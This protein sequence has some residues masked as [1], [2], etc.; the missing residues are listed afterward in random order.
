MAYTSVTAEIVIARGNGKFLYCHDDEKYYTRDGSVKEGAN[1]KCRNR[2]C[3]ARLVKPNGP[4]HIETI[5][6]A[7]SKPHNHNNSDK[8]DFINLKAKQSMRET[9]SNVHSI[10]SGPSVTS[11]K[12]IYD[13][14][15]IE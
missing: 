13:E 8:A 5:R 3:S 15:I 10:A 7:K 2:K 12:A 4:D 11:S 6:L 1:Y 14:V 9:A